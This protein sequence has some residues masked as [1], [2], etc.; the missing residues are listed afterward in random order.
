[1]ISTYTIRTLVSVASLLAATIKKILIITTS[2]GMS[3]QLRVVYCNRSYPA[4]TAKFE[5]YINI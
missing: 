5:V 4:L 3:D 1:M 2:S